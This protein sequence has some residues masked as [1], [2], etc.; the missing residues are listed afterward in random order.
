MLEG[1][2]GAT[3]D[4]G[5]SVSPEFAL[6]SIYVIYLSTKKARKR[7]RNVPTTYPD[8]TD[9][10]KYLLTLSYRDPTTPGDTGGRAL[11]QT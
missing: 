8:R 5:L 9:K 4:E 6:R 1:A 10:G 2:N 7:K 11:S 3:A